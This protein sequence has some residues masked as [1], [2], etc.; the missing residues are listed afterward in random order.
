MNNISYDI[1][2]CARSWIGTRF[3]HQGRLKKTATHK[4]GVDCL[5]LLIGVAS[6]V[7]LT[8]QGG[9]PIS[10][11]DNTQYSRTPDTTRLRQ[12]LGTLLMPKP[13][14][15]IA[16]G[17]V[18]LFK[19]DGNPQ[20]LAVIGQGGDGQL[21]MIHSYAQ[22]RK[23]TEHALDSHWRKS[24]VAAYGMQ[25]VSPPLARSDKNRVPL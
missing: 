11:F 10:H 12:L 5:G 13:I 20:H 9:K 6:E 16:P 14:A 21:S 25:Y 4:G 18:G 19:L 7:G 23:V 24:L 1:I 3:L 2:T 15:Q 8:D 17:D 22:A